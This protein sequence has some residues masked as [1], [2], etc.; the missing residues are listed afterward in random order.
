MSKVVLCETEEAVVVYRIE[1]INQTFS[2]YEE[3]CYLIEQYLIFFLTEGIPFGMKVYLKEELGIYLKNDDTM[4]QLKYII[5]FRNY[6]TTDEKHQLAQRLRTVY[7]YSAA[8]KQK[9]MAD[10][11]LSKHLYLGAL[12]AYQAVEKRLGQFHSREKADVFYHMGLCQS[13]M[14]CLEEAKE[15]FMKSLSI[16]EQKEVQ[17][18][19]FM[20]SYLQGDYAAFLE[21]GKKISFSEDRC[22]LIYHNIKK[23]EDEIKSQEEFV[24][25][26]KID[27]HRKKADDVMT[28]RLTKAIL[29]KW[30][31]EYKNEII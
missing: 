5:N 6:F 11:F 17:E 16:K 3:L 20:L 7:L 21:D 1:K 26:K 18:A 12:R 30:K 24:K 8:K 19:Y 28:R 13:R 22:R 23:R 4:E 27:Y 14:F 9:L 15:S 2:S 25:L 31:D 29:E 10:L